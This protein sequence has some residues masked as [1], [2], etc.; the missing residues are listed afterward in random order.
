M[1][2]TQTTRKRSFGVRS[3]SVVLALLLILSTC[4]VMFTVSMFS[5]SAA[6]D[7]WFVS[8]NFNNWT[9]TATSVNKINGSSGSVTIPMTASS[10]KFKM[11][12]NESGSKWCGNSDGTLTVGTKKELSWN[13]GKDI[14][15]ALPAN[16]VAVTFKLD[17]E[18]GKNYITVTATTSGGGGGGSSSNTYTTTVNP[19]NPSNQS[20]G[21][22]DIFWVNATYYDYMSDKELSNGWLYPDHVGTSNFNGNIDEW[23]PF[24]QFNRD[25]V[26]NVATNNSGWS[27]P[28][29]FGN[30]CNT[31]NAYDTS[32]HPGVTNGY[33]DATGSYNVTRFD[34]AANNSNGVYDRN[35]SVQGL[36]GNSLQ[37]G[38]LQ[39]PDGTLAP[40]FN[41]SA[42]GNK[43]NIVKSS[44]PFRT[45]DYG[46]Y[47]RYE[48]DST[49]AK[50]NVFFTW[51]TKNGVT[52]PKYVN[53][54]AGTTYGVKDGLKE[55]MN[56]T[57]GYGIFPFNNA[58]AN[59]KGTKTKTNEQLDYGFGIR[60]D[61]KFR[62]P[63]NT[64]VSFDFSG[65]DDLWMYITD[66]TTKQSTL[67]LDM[68]GS[69][70]ESEG[71]VNFYKESDGVVDFTTAQGIVDKVDNPNAAN[72]DIWV[73]D[74]SNWGSVKIYAWDN[75]GNGEWYTGDS[76]S[77]LYR[78]R[79]NIKGSKGNLLSTKTKFLFAKDTNYTNQSGDLNISDRKN[80][81]SY[82]DNFGWTD[83][84]N[85]TTKGHC[86]KST[87]DF[88]FNPD[89]TYTMTIF[90]ME[91]G[92]IESN[93]KMGFTITPLGNNYVVTERINTTNIN[94][95]LQ[96]KV[97][98]LSEFGFNPFN[99]DVQLDDSTGYSDFKLSNGGYIEI[100]KSAL[101]INSVVKIQQYATKNSYLV[102][103]AKWDYYDKENGMKQFA[104]GGEGTGI[105]SKTGNRKTTTANQTLINSESNDP[106]DYA[107]LQVDY[108]NTPKSADVTVTKTTTDSSTAE[109]GATVY[110]ALDYDNSG[111]PIYSTYDLE[112]T[113]NKSSGTHTA[114]GGR[115]TLQNGKVLTFKGIPEGARM[116]VVEDNS[117]EY[118]ATYSHSAASP[119]IVGTSNA[120]TVT[121]TPKAVNP[122]QK[123]IT[124]K[125]TFD[126]QDY[127][128]TLFKFGIK[129]LNI[130]DDTA[131][132]AKDTTAVSQEVVSVSNGT[133]TFDQLTFTEAGVYRY[134]VYE[135]T[136]YLV[137]QGSTYAQD[138]TKT[139]SNF[140]ATITVTK[141]GT[142]LTASNPVFT[143]TDKTSAA[144]ITASD[145]SG[146]SL[147][148][149]TF[150]NVAQKGSLTINKT[151]QSG[152]NVGSVKFA[153][154]K[155]EDSYVDT[156]D[157]MSDA[158]R[159]DAILA[160]D[161]SAKVSEQTTNTN[162][163]A[164][165]KNLNIYESGY[166]SSE[167][168]YTS[169]GKP[170]Y[171]NYALIEIG[172]NAD[173]HINKTP[174]IFKF[175]TYDTKE[176][177]YK[178]HYAF[179]YVNGMIRNPYTAG[180][181]MNAFKLAGMFIVGMSL[182]ALAG[183]VLYKKRNNKSLSKAKHY[184]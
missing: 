4:V 38:Q 97:M 160:L 99:N 125:K 52:Y 151:N 78:F 115:I 15:C 61:M 112:Y 53:Y 173:Y 67:A 128:G 10:I 120:L 73:K 182:L 93:C 91:R 137:E 45:T 23:Y 121:N 64:K 87:K 154:Y 135:D 60:M 162:G 132:N 40:Y 71:R 143:P 170:K 84:N 148:T 133:I 157:R 126:G 82:T 83:T 27:K 156:L 21:G 139:S 13:G 89:H 68:G 56:T 18:N 75:N 153:L 69:H 181:G 12:A 7:Y 86:E 127:S 113:D 169:S 29:Y 47:K 81:C 147:T 123:T 104:T 46:T 158:D 110:L 39:T 1:V 159:Y 5:A 144:D 34:Y 166:T 142:T 48:F 58:S 130:P 119:A 108:E 76:S 44:F 54:G 124:A 50:D 101:P 88:A 163:V 161:D 111:N 49:G 136:S 140:I 26:K 102:Y 138:I 17:V 74:T 31:Y 167:P 66:E 150:T 118:N 19:N 172:G 72:S 96:T 171:Q 98:G 36:M 57:S 177:V 175:P 105:T 176:H 149:A 107:E 178:Y 155:I 2:K 14:T 59:Y 168:G 109:F 3:L 25:I 165:F 145:L 28:L 37:Y 30:F 24:Y 62:I 8:G 100:P 122:A 114:A 92:L 146:E 42:L 20:S 106:Y 70:K 11:V 174:Q 16:T 129:G 77:N 90:Y 43:A 117:E 95:G 94:P 6:I 183:F 134:F 180:N 141:S 51:E 63:E 131:A 152:E 9:Q 41:E 32:H 164:E 80:K 33:N 55:F 116:Y 85:I 35:T 103:D 22:Q 79:D 179:D 184:K 65:D